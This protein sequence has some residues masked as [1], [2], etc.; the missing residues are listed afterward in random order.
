MVSKV[1]FMLCDFYLNFLKKIKQL[2][3]KN[4]K[5][6]QTQN[7]EHIQESLTPNTVNKTAARGLDGVMVQD[8]VCGD[9]ASFL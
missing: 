2:N 6:K 5:K 8:V 1:N 7:K 9:E 4:K 3:S